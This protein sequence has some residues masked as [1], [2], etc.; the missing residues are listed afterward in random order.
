MIKLIIMTLIL[1]IV[2]PANAEI[3][4]L[5]NYQGKLADEE[6]NP[7]DGTKS[8][9]FRIYDASSN[10]SLLWSETQSVTIYKGIFNILLGAAANLDL[11]F[12]RPYYLALKV[13]S[14]SEMTPRQRIVSVGNAIRVEVAPLLAHQNLYTDLDVGA[15]DGFSAYETP[16]PNH[17]LVLD[18]NGN[19]PNEIFTK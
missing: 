10:G 19:V 17:L 4:H 12:D 2:I 14:D 13:E 1:L 5:I 6:G 3:P 7:I 9:T 8:I 15:V 18:E 11:T 16:N